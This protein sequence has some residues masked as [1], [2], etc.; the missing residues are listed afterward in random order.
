MEQK[1][2][3]SEQGPQRRPSNRR[4]RRRRRR[5]PAARPA[6]APAANRTPAARDDAARAAAAPATGEP[7]GPVPAQDTGEPRDPVAVP[8]LAAVAAPATGPRTCPLCTEPVDD[9]YTAIAYGERG[10]PAHF[11]CIVSLL[12]EREELEEG[13]RLCYLGGGSF[14]IVQMRPSARSGDRGGTLLIHKRIE[15]EERD[16]APAW[17]EE[18]RLPM[19]ARRVHFAT[20]EVAT[21]EG[22]PCK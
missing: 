11:D 22:A 3:S 17:R 21:S 5:S 20:S 10:A 19:P 2:S 13:A 4:R 1:H 9:L 14:G 8:E 7:R 6:P 12:G 15:V 16:S 18:L